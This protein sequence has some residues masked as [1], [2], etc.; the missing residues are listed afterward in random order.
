M[1]TT[2]EKKDMYAI[3]NNMIMEKL[4]NGKMPWKQTWSNYGPARN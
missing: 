4:K 1:K 3:I 2:T